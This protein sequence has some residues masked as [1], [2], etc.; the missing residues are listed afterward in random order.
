MNITEIKYSL[1]P[2]QFRPGVKFAEDSNISM[3]TL[4]AI[5]ISADAEALQQAM[6]M[7][8]KNAALDAAPDMVTTPSTMTPVQFL[9]YWM[10]KAI[11]A[12]T[13]KRDIDEVLGRQTA[14]SF[15]DAEVVQPVV[16][17][18]GEALPYGDRVNGALADF[19]VNYEARTIVRQELDLE[20]GKLEEEQASRSR[21]NAAQLKREAVRVGLEIER[22]LI[23]FY[24][25]NE[26]LNKTYGVL[27]DPNL[28]AYET[29]PAVSYGGDTTT[30]WQ[31][32]TFEQIQADLLLAF[33]QL[34]T[35][36]G[37]NV[38]PNKDSIRLVLSANRVEF[39]DKTNAYGTKT[40]REWLK[41]TYPRVEIVASQWFNSV[42]GG[43]NVFY[44]IA[45]KINGSDVALQPTQD[46]LRLMGV[47]NKGKVYEEQY[48]NAT[49]G[50][51]I[52]QP[53]GVV[54]YTGI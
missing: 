40:V 50:A 45:D 44:L 41:E 42:N 32:K 37:Q 46:V 49:A 1:K 30:S 29:V 16:E 6:A 39:L 12:A 5:G 17:L 33:N 13:T 4:G 21:L 48:A 54:R 38:D 23:G 47:Y 9:Q 19:N 18:T 52:V 20:V 31:Y 8:A 10:P 25:F 51:F 11:I 27:N 35:Q 7:N 3:A 34:R 26:G 28:S 53:I 15:A 43:Q 2:G 22:N 14:G 24:G 36:S